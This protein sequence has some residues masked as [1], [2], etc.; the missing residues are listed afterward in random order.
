M[1]HPI[2]RRWYPVVFSVA[3][4]VLLPLSILSRAVREDF[5]PAQLAR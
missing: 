1:S 3:A 2:Q 5:I 4:L